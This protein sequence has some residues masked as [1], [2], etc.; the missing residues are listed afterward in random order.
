[1][2]CTIKDET[3]QEA[4]RLDTPQQRLLPYSRESSPRARRLAHLID[5]SA[6]AARIEPLASRGDDRPMPTQRSSSS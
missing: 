3:I 6:S 1:M 5:R 2:A 4:D